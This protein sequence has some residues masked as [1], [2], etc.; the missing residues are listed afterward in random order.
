MAMILRFVELS[1]F[2]GWLIIASI[3]FGVIIG[4][5]RIFVLYIV[6]S[7]AVKT[8]K[9]LVF[10]N[11]LSHYKFVAAIKICHSLK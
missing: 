5:E 10:E 8:T 7:L 11:I 3:F 6:N 4:C 1:G 9:D 2:T